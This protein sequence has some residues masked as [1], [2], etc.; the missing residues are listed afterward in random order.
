VPDIGSAL[1]SLFHLKKA[2]LFQDL[3]GFTH[4]AASG[5]ELGLHL[6]L[7]R[8]PL[9]GSEP[10]ANDGGLYL[11]SDF[12]TCTTCLDREE[13][14]EC[15]SGMF[16]WYYLICDFICFCANCAKNRLFGRTILNILSISRQ[17]ARNVLLK[18]E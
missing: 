16:Q 7:T 8:Q 6:P 4:N 2:L 5:A 14:V 13:A 18:L 10:S 1:G 11:E 3:D 9:A 15:F 17:G 12:L